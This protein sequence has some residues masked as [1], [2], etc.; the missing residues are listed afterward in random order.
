MN[1]SF[2]DQ[3]FESGK[4]GNPAGRPVGSKN[5]S[6]MVRKI[7]ALEG[8]LPEAIYRKLKDQYPDI[9]RKTSIEEVITLS[10]VSQARNGNVQ[11]YRA[12]MDSAYG[13]NVVDETSA[14]GTFEDTTYEEIEEQFYLPPKTEN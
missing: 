9:A 2:E 6:T 10:M 1:Q 5:R 11:A 3:K 13:K 12:L 8:D 7:L 4:S 14:T